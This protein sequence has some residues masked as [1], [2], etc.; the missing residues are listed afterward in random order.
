MEKKFIRAKSQENKNIRMQQI[1][2]VTDRLFH[3]K[4]YHEITLSVIA[5]EMNLARGGLYKYVSSKEEIFLMI[6]LQKQNAML[7]DIVR[8]LKNRKIT[9]DV[10]SEVMSKRSIRISTLSDI[11][12]Y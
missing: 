10:L 6:Y 8:R 2:D 5:E 9:P 12:R 11:I 4:T 3:E 7:K 1:M